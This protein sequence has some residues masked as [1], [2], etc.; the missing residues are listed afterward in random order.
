[1]VVAPFVKKSAA[2]AIII[3]NDQILVIKR[4][5]N[6]GRKYMVTPGGGIEKGEQADQALIR[7]LAEETSVIVKNP[8]L[9]FVEDPNSDV[10]GIQYIYLCEYVS[11]EPALHPESEE[12]AA[13]NTGLDWYEPTWFPCS[14]LPDTE[15]PF[16]SI[17]LCEEIVLALQNGFPDQPK[18]WQL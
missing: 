8:R 14:Q 3:H 2:R 7:E 11:G 10:W 4:H 18:K 5:R 9:V 17:R 12:Q 6:D 16:L 1:M 13:I 15:Y